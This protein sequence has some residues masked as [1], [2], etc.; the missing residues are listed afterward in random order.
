[1]A[2]LAER[3]ERKLVLDGV[4]DPRAAVR[5]PEAVGMDPSAVRP[6]DLHV[7]KVEGRRKPVN[8]RLPGDR[9]AQ[10]RREAIVDFES[11]AHLEVSREE[12]EAHAR[13][14]DARQIARLGK[15]G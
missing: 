8:P 5:L 12:A 9:D 15:E 14:R 7:P 13:R 1:M 11:L 10:E 6:A 2:E 4:L 3:P